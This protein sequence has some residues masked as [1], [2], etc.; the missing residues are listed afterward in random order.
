MANL[1]ETINTNPSR[2]YSDLNFTMTKHPVSKDIAKKTNEE[3]IKQAIKS[4]LLLRPK[5]KPFH[6]EVAGNIYGLLFENFDEPGTSEILKLDIRAILAA[7]EPRIEVQDVVI[8]SYPDQNSI[9]IRIYFV[10]I[11]TLLP[12]SVDIFIKTVR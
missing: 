9:E 11:N 12:S 4:L 8:D 7:N 1:F 10:V 3:A 2:Q 6:P 5:E